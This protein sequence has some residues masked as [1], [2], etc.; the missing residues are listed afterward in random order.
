MV[1]KKREPQ[2]KPNF[3]EIILPAG[4]G[5]PTPGMAESFV[6]E[7]TTVTEENLGYL[8]F[9]GEITGGA[10]AR[11]HQDWGHLLNLIASLIKREYYGASDRDAHTALE[12]ALRKAN[13]AISELNRATKSPWVNHLH[14]VVASLSRSSLHFA[15]TGSVAIFIKRG[16]HLMDVAAHFARTSARAGRAF[17][18]IA[19]GK[20]VPGD[21]LVMTSSRAAASFAESEHDPFVRLPAFDGMT[22]HLT[23]LL[24]KA[25][26]GPAAVLA[27][28]LAAQPELVVVESQAVPRQPPPPEP[29]PAL[30]ALNEE[31]SEVESRFDLWVRAL[32][33]ALGRVARPSVAAILTIIAVAVWGGVQ[34]SRLMR[35]EPTPVSRQAFQEARVKRDGAEKAII[36]G[37]NDEAAALLTQ[38][39]ALLDEA[40]RDPATQRDAE[41]LAADVTNLQAKAERIEAVAEL[42]VFFDAASLAVNFSADGV[43]LIKGAPVFFSSSSNVLIRLDPTK[44][45]ATTFFA[46][47]DI[48]EGVLAGAALN[49]GAVLLTTK[50]RFIAYAPEA[51]RATIVLGPAPT[52]T[53]D[54]ESFGANLY[55][56]TADTPHI[57]KNPVLGGALQEAT[58]WLNPPQSISGNRFAID[59]SIWI[60]ESA[61]QL[62]R[63]YKGKLANKFE[64]AGVSSGTVQDLEIDEDHNLIAVATVG[65][66]RIVIAEK[67]GRVI[68]QLASSA[69]SDI[70]AAMFLDDDLL[71]VTPQ[72]TYRVELP[73]D[74]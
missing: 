28:E 31:E 5:A 33:R 34:V 60:A 13:A 39:L 42:P 48:G 35:K 1:T 52:N 19:S 73:R 3:R 7:P 8:F 44:A 71:V 4:K 58:P 6:Y 16:K 25:K 74:Q 72:K 54:L 14:G 70:R 40:L 59:G 37:R 61:N 55:L 45:A 53:L 56:L 23:T 68:K 67:T 49:D 29:I 51:T 12:E 46:N 62:V 15:T 9:V 50:G 64:L 41:A 2:L 22:A 43:I 20:V 47:L 27:I 17:H 63:F 57:F 18:A 26:V 38:A 21:I 65:P 66:G 11:K 24:R 30:V 69:F 10:P 32:G 36:K